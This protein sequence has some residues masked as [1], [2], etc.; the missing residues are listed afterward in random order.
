MTETARADGR[1]SLLVRLLF[2]GVLVY[3]AVDGFRH[4]DVRVD[5]AESKGVPVPEFIV[6]VTTGMLLVSNLCL[7]VW[8]FPRAA[9]GAVILFFLGTTPTIHNFW[10]LEGEERKA[11]KINFCKNL[12][13]LGGAIHLLNEAAKDDE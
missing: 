9:A 13:I 11:N 5:I 3:M 10:A 12:V 8:R 2:S 6:P 4:N 7:L 1:P